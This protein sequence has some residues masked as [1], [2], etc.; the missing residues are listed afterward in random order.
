MSGGLYLVWIVSRTV[1]TARQATTDLSTSSA[2]S[3][4]L[5]VMK[6]LNQMSDNLLDGFDIVDQKT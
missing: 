4:C 3:G 5:L 6:K 1:S 2:T